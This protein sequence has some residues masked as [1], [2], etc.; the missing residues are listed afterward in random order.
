M[1]ML[2]SFR[3]DKQKLCLVVIKFKHA[4]SCPSL[5]SLMHVCI[6]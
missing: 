4:R 6:E 3:G 5:T 1:E 2:S